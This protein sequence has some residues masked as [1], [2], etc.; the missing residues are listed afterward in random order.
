MSSGRMAPRLA[1]I[2]VTCRAQADDMSLDGSF[3]SKLIPAVRKKTHNLYIQ[4]NLNSCRDKPTVMDIRIL[5]LLIHHKVNIKTLNVSS[6]SSP[7]VCN[8]VITT[9]VSHQ[10]VHHETRCAC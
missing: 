9:A 4:D 3:I 8:L 10:L 7:N 2:L 1:T 6:S 5:Q